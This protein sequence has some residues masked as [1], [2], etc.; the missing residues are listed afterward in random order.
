[1]YP[2]CEV[3][4]DLQSQRDQPSRSRNLTSLARTYCR[5]RGG[6][7]GWSL[8][9]VA[10]R[11]PPSRRSLTISLS[12]SR[13]A[14]ARRLLSPPPSLSLSL[15]AVVEARSTFVTSIRARIVEIN[16]LV[17]RQKSTWP[18]R[19]SRRSVAASP[20]SSYASFERRDARYQSRYLQARE[21]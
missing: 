7:G 2:P 13:S 8:V 3:K 11:F 4:W 15:G 10:P 5:K 9:I 17:T 16:L 18:R 14:A 6:G 20:S 19:P 12:L 21:I 1:M